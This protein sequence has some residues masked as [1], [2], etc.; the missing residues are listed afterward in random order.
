MRS[1]VRRSIWKLASTLSALVSLACGDGVRRGEEV[2]N[3]DPLID[4]GCPGEERCR[5][6]ADGDTVCL[7]PSAAITGAACAVESCPSGE[8]CVLV[9][10]VLG[11]HRVCRIGEDTAGCVCAYRIADGAPWGVCPRACTIGE[12]CPE[13]GATCA[14]TPALAYPICVG[15]GPVGL[16]ESCSDARCAAGLGCLARAGEPRC[17]RLCRPDL[18]SSCP[19]A[20]HCGGLVDG[21]SGVGYC[22]AP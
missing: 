6:L 20:E 17:Q 21:V 2:A 10:G 4:A 15:V 7:P 12:A 16:D 22:V 5:L 8:A 14:P 13:L 11:C 18:D 19:P 1:Q 9:E 3:C